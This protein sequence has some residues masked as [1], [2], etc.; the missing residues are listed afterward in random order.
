MV[1]RLTY[2]LGVTSRVKRS[3]SMVHLTFTRILLVRSER[4]PYT[5]EALFNDSCLPPYILSAYPCLTSVLEISDK[6]SSHISLASV[7]QIEIEIG[8]KII[9]QLVS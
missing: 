5:R 4:H 3:I 2:A 9:G 1:A 7:K 6:D 8:F